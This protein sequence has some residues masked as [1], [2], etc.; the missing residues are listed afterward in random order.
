MLITAHVCRR[1]LVDVHLSGGAGHIPL[2]EEPSMHTATR[3]PGTYAVES[4]LA[5]GKD[6][7]TT[8]FSK[9]PGH[10]LFDEEQ[11]TADEVLEGNAYLLDPHLALDRVRPRAPAALIRAEHLLAGVG[12][13]EKEGDAWRN[14]QYDVGRGEALLRKQVPRPPRFD[15]QFMLGRE[16][17]GRWVPA[18]GCLSRHI[19]QPNYS[20][21]SIGG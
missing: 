14:A 15:P 7:H 2:V 8:D 12:E 5:V 4:H 3:G 11:P 17:G 16:D 21:L 10:N 9:G 19:N 13:D 20:C 1:R 6:A 18:H